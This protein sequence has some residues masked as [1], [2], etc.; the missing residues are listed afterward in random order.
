MEETKEKEFPTF[1]D[2]HNHQN[3]RFYLAEGFLK[4]LES[5]GIGFHEVSPYFPP[6]KKG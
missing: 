1:G 5:L 4:K 6:P 3:V 2:F